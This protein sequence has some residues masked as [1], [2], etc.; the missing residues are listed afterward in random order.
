[1]YYSNVSGSG[2]FPAEYLP[3]ELYQERSSGYESDTFDPRLSYY[4]QA[5]PAS[6]TTQPST[7]EVESLTGIPVSL[8]NAHQIDSISS[9]LGGHGDFDL[10]RENARLDEHIAA[11]LELQGPI[12]AQASRHTY[13]PYARPTIAQAT[14]PLTVSPRELMLPA[15]GLDASQGMPPTWNQFTSTAM[16]PLLPPYGSGIQVPQVPQA[17]AVPLSSISMRVAE[18]AKKKN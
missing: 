11:I 9:G 16:N 4:P 6:E 5:S 14:P 10:A 13:Q 18:P 3:Q 1:M 7:P 8:E 2:S 15:Y 17:L 12:R